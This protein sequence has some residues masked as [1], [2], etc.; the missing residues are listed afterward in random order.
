MNS[1]FHIKDL[2]PLKYFLGIDV[3]RSPQGL[4]PR[5]RKYALEIIEE[6]GL[7]G[8]K[9]VGFPMEANYKLA[10]P[11]RPVIKDPTR[12]RRLVGRLIYLTITR[13]ELCYAV[14]ILSQFMQA[15]KEAHMEAARRVLQYLKGN[16]G[17]GLLL[18]VTPDLNVSAFCDSDWGACP[19]TR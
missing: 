14:H 12:Y 1:C 19:L 15:P 10:L 7:L 9:S 4:F 18:K 16:P 2:G 5:Q 17:Q 11:D 3:A 6:C 13:P 8:S